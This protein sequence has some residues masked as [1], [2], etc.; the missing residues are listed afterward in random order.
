MDSTSSLLLIRINL[1]Q[2]DDRQIVVK[3]TSLAKRDEANHRWHAFLAA[4]NTSS[5][6]SKQKCGYLRT[7]LGSQHLPP[8]D[9]DSGF[10]VSS[11]TCPRCSPDIPKAWSGSMALTAVWPDHNFTHCRCRTWTQSYPGHSTL[12]QSILIPSSLILLSASPLNLLCSLGPLPESDTGTCTRSC[13][14]H[15]RYSNSKGV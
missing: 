13:C 9:H 11:W 4:D 10:R 2:K 1:L 7:S 3:S 14:S 15:R 5:A 12:M 8:A 6:R